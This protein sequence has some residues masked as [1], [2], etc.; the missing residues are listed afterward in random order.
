MYH[1][2]VVVVLE[3]TIALSTVMMV[4][5]LMLSA[6]FSCRPSLIAARTFEGPV[7][8]VIHVLITCYLAIEPSRAGVAF[9]LRCRMSG[10]A[11]MILSSFP[12]GW[13]FLATRTTL[14]IV[15]PRHNGSEANSQ[16][17]CASRC[18]RLIHPLSGACLANGTAGGLV[19]FFFSC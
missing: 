1:L 9:K 16:Q 6:L 10:S 15:D 18:E 2:D 5:N 14:E 4:S 19:T 13:E 12:A 3:R 11:T 17:D 8:S 7:V